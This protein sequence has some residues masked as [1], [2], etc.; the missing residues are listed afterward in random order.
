MSRRSL[1]V[2]ATV[3][4][5][6]HSPLISAEE[7]QRPANSKASAKR[8]IYT[9]PMHPEIQWSR[10]DKCPICDMKLVAKNGQAQP[11]AQETHDDAGMPMHSDEMR[12]GHHTMGP[13]MM[14][15]GCS[16]CMEMMGMRGMNGHSGKAV[17]PARQSSRPTYRT[18]S[19]GRSMGRCGC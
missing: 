13:M 4:V 1:I 17:A 19:P 5:L 3:L 10:A 15:C 7:G 9:C 2:A 11:A 18:Y 12:N 6:A 16:M 14:G 8:E